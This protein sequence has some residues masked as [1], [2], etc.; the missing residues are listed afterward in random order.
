MAHRNSRAA[1]LRPVDPRTA[2]RMGGPGFNS[3]DPGVAV[4]VAVK[5]IRMASAPLDIKAP[6][7]IKL[8]EGEGFEPPEALPPQRFSRPPQSTTLPS[9]RVA[10][11][12]M[13]PPR[14]VGHATL[15][16]AL[17]Q[18]GEGSATPNSRTAR[19][20]KPAPAV[21][22]TSTPPAAKSPATPIPRATPP[23]TA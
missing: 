20:R 6:V 19:A 8:A 3:W 18:A 22:T 17:A 7:E 12:L 2:I 1:A 14:T 10:P 15:D 21:I 13:I 9:L 5:C 16:G 23:E 11:A 4:T